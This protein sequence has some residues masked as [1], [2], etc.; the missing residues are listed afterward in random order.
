MGFFKRKR[1]SSDPT[2]TEHTYQKRARIRAAAEGEINLFE[3]TASV[4]SSPTQPPMDDSYNNSIEADEDNS[5]YSLPPPQIPIPAT[6]GSPVAST[7]TKVIQEIN[8]P[9]SE[10]EKTP[11]KRSIGRSL[12]ISPRK[13]LRPSAWRLDK[14]ARVEEQM[15]ASAQ[16]RKNSKALR[17]AAAESAKKAQ[18][19]AKQGEKAFRASLI[20]KNITKPLG[21][22]GFGFKNLQE[23]VDS[24]TDAEISLDQQTES[25]LTRLAKSRGAKLAD[26]FLSRAPEQK[27][28][29]LSEEVKKRLA[30]EGKAIQTL[31]SRDH[32]TGISELLS[33]FSLSYLVTELK[34][35]APTLWEYLWD[36]A[37]NPDR[38][39]AVKERNGDIV[40]ATGCAMLAVLRSQRANNFQAV[41]GLFFIGSGASKRQMEVLAHAGI[42]LSYPAVIRHMRILFK[43]ATHTY[44]TLIQEC[45]CFIVWDNLCIQFRVDSQRLDSKD[46]FDNG[47][48]ATVI[49]LWN[50]FTQSTRTPHSTLPLSMK[51]LRTTTNPTFKWDDKAVLP[52]PENIRQLGACCKWQIKRL[53]IEAIPSLS[54]IER[55]LEP[56]PIVDQ[57]ALHQ[58]EQ[59]PLPAMKL[60]ENSIDGTL[61]VYH[62]ILKN[63]N[64]TNEDLIRHGIL[65]N[66]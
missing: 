17:R 11:V 14:E 64:V 21:E 20:F 53:A 48:T 55:T 44:Q 10:M 13:S 38:R 3:A 58:T 56:C 7:S 59:Y 52:S 28:L 33:E 24:F 23:W 25:A 34:D 29:F 5:S 18:I 49:P 50:P 51:P 22:G 26:Y 4:P 54:H 60:E 66:D 6:P 43:E 37:E 31:L 32:H 9:L 42:S 63:L 30:K 19:A 12:T 61:R 65:F 40:L 27:E 39:T 36:V 41:M 1:R 46:H 15:V 57:I 35:T 45:M 62:T 16:R 2:Y 8:S 47:T